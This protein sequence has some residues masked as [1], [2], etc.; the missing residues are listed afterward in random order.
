MTCLLSS[1]GH[2]LL[3]P[4]N[5]DS[6]IPASQNHHKQVEALLYE[7]K[8]LKTNMY[9]LATELKAARNKKGLSPTRV[10]NDSG[11]LEGKGPSPNY[12][13]F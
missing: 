3:S 10:R 13:L 7:N 8:T 4:R 12:R 2:E 1:S 9:W 6:D 5:S 11:G